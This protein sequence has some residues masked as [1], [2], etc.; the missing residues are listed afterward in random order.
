MRIKGIM[1][2]IM[3]GEHWENLERA[4]LKNFRI[5]KYSRFFP[6]TNEL[7]NFDEFRQNY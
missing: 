7:S 2:G 5:L 6:Y 4:K 1:G 3:G